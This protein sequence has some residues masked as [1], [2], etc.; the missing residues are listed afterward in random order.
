MNSTQL[1]GYNYILRN[2]YSK[3]ILTTLLSFTLLFLAS[4]AN[5]YKPS[6]E[7]GDFPTTSGNPVDLTQETVFT[8]TVYTGDFTRT[9]FVT[10]G[11]TADFEGTFPETAAN[12]NGQAYGIYIVNNKVTVSAPMSQIVEAQAYKDGDVYTARKDTEGGDGTTMKSYVQFTISG[13]TINVI[14]YVV[15]LTTDGVNARATYT[16]TLTKDTTS[17]GN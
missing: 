5:A 10:S 6:D 2:S 13:D 17:A 1:N 7:A 14:R 16:A 8:G 15:E 11:N 3:K 9:E 12:G 4:C